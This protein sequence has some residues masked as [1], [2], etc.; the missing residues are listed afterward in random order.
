MKLQTF[1]GYS[2]FLKQVK[3]R[4]RF[5]QI[6]ANLSVNHELIM[7]YWDIGRLVSEK[8]SKEGWGTKVIDRLAND[9]KNDLSA[10]IKGFSSR[11][12]G[13]MKAF[14][15]EYPM[16]SEPVEKGTAILPQAVA[17][18]TD[19]TIQNLQTYAMQI[20][21]GHNIILIEKIKD[22][23][24]RLWYMQQTI[25]YGWSRNILDLQIKSGLYMRKGKAITNFEKTL[26]PFQSDLAQQTLK[27]PYI[28][29]FLTLDADFK[30]REL[31]TGLINHLQDFL[32]ELGIGFAFVGRQ[33]HLEIGEKDFYI[34]LLFY[35]LKLRCFV[36]IELKKG[37]FEPSY[38]GKLNFYLNVVD[39]K[40][41]HPDDNPTIGLILCQD[42]N[43]VV[44]EYALRGINK[45]IGV[46]E[47]ELTQ[48]L[49]EELKSS[50][51]AIE[52][53]EKEFSG[54]D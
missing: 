23:E 19:S 54:E 43:E 29:D 18:L 33:Y 1:K 41:C 7:L 8:Q 48:S 24:E 28:F 6:K 3:E 40:L 51:P 4:I 27:D 5:A 31:E 25:E 26:P 20:P 37:A 45:A 39:D 12:I 14:Y 15:N 46:S 16:S 47:Y 13:R 9:L 44:A 17:K 36:V 49:P 10:E 21:W 30:E 35:H 32:I 53:L 11:N 42:K 52:D 34:D 2:L 50:L 22:H 38:A